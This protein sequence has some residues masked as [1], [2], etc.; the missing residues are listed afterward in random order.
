VVS[1]FLLHGLCDVLPP[2]RPSLK[3][4]ISLAPFHPASSLIHTVSQ[5]QVPP[6]RWV[7]RMLTN[8]KHHKPQ[9]S[10]RRRSLS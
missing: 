1:S 3:L 2:Q 9:P 5:P 6:G 10:P 7:A 8:N 4:T